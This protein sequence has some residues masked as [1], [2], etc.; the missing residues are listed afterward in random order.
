MD[1]MNEAMAGSE[2]E[3]GRRRGT[4]ANTSSPQ[5]RSLRQLIAEIDKEYLDQVM[6]KAE[7]FVADEFHW[8]SARRQLL[9]TLNKATELRMAAINNVLEPERNG[10]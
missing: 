9:N 8:V 1:V 3:T 7:L 4:L 5:T 2:V 6:G 10:Q